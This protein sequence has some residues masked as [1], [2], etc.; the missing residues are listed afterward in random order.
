MEEGSSG[1]SRRPF[2]FF[3]RV[4]QRR[5]KTSHRDQFSSSK[6]NKM[7]WLIQKHFKNQPTGYWQQH[8]EKC[9]EK[10]LIKYS[11]KVIKDQHPT[12]ISGFL[13]WVCKW[14]SALMKYFHFDLSK[15]AAQ[16]RSGHHLNLWITAERCLPTQNCVQA[17]FLHTCWSIIARVAEMATRARTR[18]V[19]TP[20]RPHWSLPGVH[21]M[22][23]IN[24]T[25]VVK[26]TVG[27][28]M[29]SIVRSISRSDLHRRVLQL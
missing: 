18:N 23:T 22:N 11:H 2:V 6:R 10:I 3:S 16:F 5:H 20:P 24:H 28:T 9:S 25:S 12:K 19:R 17:K 13:W 26:Y 29:R 7:F 4:C 1:L 21:L 27:G 8:N 15:H 14:G